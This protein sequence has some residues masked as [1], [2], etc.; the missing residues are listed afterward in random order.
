MRRL[1]YPT[2]LCLAGLV[3]ACPAFDEK[4]AVSNPLSPADITITTS[5]PRVVSLDIR[6]VGSI[7]GTAEIHLMLDGK[8]YKTEMLSGQVSFRWGGDWYS[9]TAEIRYRP[10]KVE[11]GKL[12]LRYH[13]G[14][15]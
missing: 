7:K 2:V 8:T 4:V 9:P 3:A 12:E 6:G 15:I 1:T 11:S 10:V 14:T 13:F 5:N